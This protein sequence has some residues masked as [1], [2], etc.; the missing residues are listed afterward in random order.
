MIFP[1]LGPHGHL[2]MYHLESEQDAKSEMDFTV[3]LNA[4]KSREHWVGACQNPEAE[5]RRWAGN[6]DAP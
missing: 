2:Y 6:S 3:A 4:T 1:I 5:A